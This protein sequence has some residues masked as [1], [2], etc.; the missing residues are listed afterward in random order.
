MPWFSRPGERYDT[1]QPKG[2]RSLARPLLSQLAPA[3]PRETGRASVEAAH[4]GQK[5]HRFTP[6]FHSY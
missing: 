6:S 5:L 1:G 3:F 2:P 4:S